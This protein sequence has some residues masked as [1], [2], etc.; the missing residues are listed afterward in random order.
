[1]TEIDGREGPAL[2][3]ERRSPGFTLTEYDAHQERRRARGRWSLG[4]VPFYRPDGR[5]DP[6]AWHDFDYLDAYQE[7]YGRRCG[8]AGIG[9]LREVAIVRPSADDEYSNHPYFHEDQRVHEPRRL[10]PAVGQARRR[11]AGRR[12][13]GVRREVRGERRQGLLARIPR[14]A[15]GR[16][17]PDDEHAFGRRTD[18]RSRRRHHRQEELRPVADRG[19]RPH[20]VF[21]ALGAVEPRRPGALHR[22]RR[23][24]LGDGQLARRRRV[25]ERHRHRGGTGAA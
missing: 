6:L 8:S 14:E 19:L 23:S 16:V 13:R 21:R 7:V 17:R 5:Q 9:R 12:G 15:D 11:P 1:M 22:D 20:R 18:D 10:L 2:P 25:H 4:E 24:L 3:E